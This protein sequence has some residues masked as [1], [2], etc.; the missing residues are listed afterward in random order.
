M[1]IEMMNISDYLMVGEA[2]EFLG[3]CKETLR[4]WERQKKLKSYRHPFNKYRLYK[5]EE[6]KA[7]LEEFKQK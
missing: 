3:V 6:L 4:N 1:G 5:I 7:F 2:A